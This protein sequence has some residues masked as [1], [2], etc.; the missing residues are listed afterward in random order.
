MFAT[1][2]SIEGMKICI[3]NASPGTDEDL[4][5]DGDGMPSYNRSA[6]NA[7]VVSNFDKTL[8]C[9]GSEYGGVGQTG[10]ITVWSAVD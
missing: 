1:S 3:P 5:A 10:H 6:G 8:R 4:L 7:A 2:V 9:E